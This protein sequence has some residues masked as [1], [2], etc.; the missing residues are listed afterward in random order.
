MRHAEGLKQEL[1]VFVPPESPVKLA[2]LK[3]TNPSDRERRLT[4]TY[5]AQWLLG[6]LAS[7]A[8]PH[9]V[10]GFDA[11][12]QALIAR[13]DWGAEFAGRIAFLAASHPPHSLSCDR[14]SFLGRQQNMAQPA[15]LV[16]WSLDGVLDKVADPAAAFQVHID[17]AAGA[18]EEV[19]FVLGEG[20]DLAHV[21]KLAA[22]WTQLASVKQGLADNHHQW[23]ERLH[24][25][26]VTTPDPAF[27]L[28]VNRWLLNQNIASRI[29]ARAGFQQAGGAFGFRDQLQDMMALLFSDPKRVRA[30]ILT[31]AARQFEEGD[32]LHWWHP[33]LGRGVKTHFSDDL[34]WLVY[35]TGRYVKATGDVSILTEPVPFLSAP[36]LA[37]DEPDRYSLFEHGDE[38]DTLFEHCRRALNHGVTKGVHGLP[39]M[40]SGDWNDGMDRVGSK[41]RGE[42]VWLAWFAA[43]CAES[44]AEL[45]TLMNRSDLQEYWH[46]RARELRQAADHTAW[47]GNWYM[48]AF[49]DDGLPWGSK[50][51]E[52]CQIDSISQSW[53]V[54]AKSLSAERSRIGLNSATER[55]LDRSARLIRLLTPSFTKGARDPGY[56]AAYPPGVR[57]NGGQYTHAAAWLGLAHAQLANG[58]L[59]YEVFDLINPIRRSASL[60][61]AWHYRA[62]PYVLAADIR[63]VEPHIGEAGWSWYTGAAGWTWQLAIEGILGITLQQ[64]EICIAP[65]MPAHWQKVDV[66]IKGPKGGG[67][68]I[69]L[70]NPERLATG[71]VELWVDGKRLKQER[72]TLPQDGSELQVTARLQRP[73]ATE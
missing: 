24:T 1:T 38:T 33:P 2:L 4:V 73:T 35:A 53:A 70:D 46:R 72:L 39:L 65:N 67:L 51:N 5:Y 55:L 41:G 7:T 27:D 11:T 36:P 20:E 29:L 28:M 3:L 66:Y 15:G 50:D 61:G 26:Q 30:H 44:F 47:D 59:A 16:A 71:Q 21:R 31:C 63:S 8:Q 52:Q 25:I 9:V 17:L 58:D 56:I 62:E 54:L 64:G 40:G 13:N 57:E 48:R 10:T 34:L 43:S 49:A 68:N 19:V 6:A 18:T 60:D 14:A 32:V 23:Q 37:D 69:T 42:S 22:N 12:S 45:A